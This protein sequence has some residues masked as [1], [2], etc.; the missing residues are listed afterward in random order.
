MEK[1]NSNNIQIS[2]NESKLEI[3]VVFGNITHDL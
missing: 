3:P 1:G 2:E